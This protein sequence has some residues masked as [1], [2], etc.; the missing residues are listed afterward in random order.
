MLQ[1]QLKKLVVP[2]LP[3]KVIFLLKLS[4]FCATVHMLAMV[5]FFLLPDYKQTVFLDMTHNNN[6]PLVFVPLLKTAVFE[7]QKNISSNVQSQKTSLQ[8]KSAVQ[9]SSVKNVL[10]PLKNIKEIPIKKTLPVKAPVTKKIALNKKTTS[11]SKKPEP[12]KL[13]Q[14]PKT[15]AKPLPLQ[16]KQEVIKPTVA[17][18]KQEEL[19]KIELKNSSAAIPESLVSTTSQDPTFMMVGREDKDLILL[20]TVLKQDIVKCWKRPANIPEQ[21]AC[22]VRVI[23]NKDGTTRDVII[24]KTSNA[25]A[26]DISARNFLLSYDFPK[27]AFGKELSIIF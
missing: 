2:K 20:S 27:Q 6:A 16:K 12:V 8:K 1:L 3:K 5:L 18:I 22:H 19:K 4:F 25:M 13:V 14:K 15:I 11:I 26:L 7:Q 21:A 24:E 9:S 17:Q 23:I 10:Q